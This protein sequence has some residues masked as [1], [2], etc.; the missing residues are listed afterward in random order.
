MGTFEECRKFDMA[1]SCVYV[2]ERDVEIE[3][4]LGEGPRLEV[5]STSPTNKRK[6]K[7]RYIRTW[8]I[9]QSCSRLVKR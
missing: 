1:S 6:V 3:G 2:W 4:Q 5:P 9:N 7:Y 8:I